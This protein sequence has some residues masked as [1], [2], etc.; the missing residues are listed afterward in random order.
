MGFALHHDNPDWPHDKRFLSLLAI[1]M[2]FLAGT[3]GALVREHSSLVRRLEVLQ[4]DLD[5]AKGAMEDMKS[6]V[7]GFRRK[8]L[9]TTASA[10]TLVHTSSDGSTPLTVSSDVAVNVESVRFDGTNIGVSGD[11]DLMTLSTNL[12]T[13]NG[14]VKPTPV[15]C[16]A[17]PAGATFSSLSWI[18]INGL[19]FTDNLGGWNSGACTSDGIF[20]APAD[21]YYYAGATVRVDNVDSG[22]VRLIISVNDSPFGADYGYEPRSNAGHVIGGYAGAFHTY[23][24]SNIVK[25][26]SGDTI[27]FKVIS[28]DDNTWSYTSESHVVV[29]MLAHA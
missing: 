4:H 20:T 6:D 17:T 13:V 1:F 12:L 14:H 21:G 24:V 23:Q 16:Y 3:T 26:S 22:Y 7:H 9:A 5:N 25:I 15:G 18:T 10:D 11:H 8:L 28:H 19:S 29:Y 27:R 2:L